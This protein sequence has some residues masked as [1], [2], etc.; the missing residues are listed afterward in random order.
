MSDR[1]GQV[2]GNYKLLR[3]LGQGGF[4]DV[5]LAEQVHLGT[6]AAIKIL[7]TQLT[8]DN[9]EKFRT[10]ARTL[11]HLKHPNIVQVL[12]FG[13]IGATPYL[14]MQH[15]LNGTLRQRHP[16]G[17]A[18]ALNVVLSY[19]KPMA[20]ALQYAHNQRFIHRDVKP[21][22]MLIGEQNQLLLSDFGIAVV[23]SSSHQGSALVDPAGTAA[24]MAPELIQ[25]RAVV[26]SDQYAL[27]I[28][29]Y[30]WLTGGVPFNGSYMEIVSQQVSAS[31][32]SLRKKMPSLPVDV[33]E[34]IMIAL[35]KDP[36]KRFGRIEAFAQALAQAAQSKQ[37]AVNVSSQ[38][39]TPEVSTMEFALVGPLGRTILG[40]TKVTI[41]RAPD[42]TLVLPDANV[43]Q[44]HAELRPEGPFYSLID[45]SNGYGTF[46]NE[47]LMYG[48]MPRMLQPSD[49]I[50]IG[51]TKF[52]FTVDSGAQKAYSVSSDQLPPVLP[53]YV[54]NTGYGMGDYPGMPAPGQPSAYPN[55]NSQLP[56]YISPAAQQS[57]N[58]PNY[59]GSPTPVPPA[60]YTPNF[61]APQNP[62]PPVNY[63]PNYSGMP[64][65]PVPQAN[66]SANYPPNYTGA[67]TPV[68]P[69]KRRSPIMMI[70][71]AVMAVIL[72][73]AGIIGFS[74]YHN[75]QVALDNT[76]ATATAVQ[77]LSNNHAT[78]TLVTQ[79]HVSATATSIV[80]LTATATTSPYPPFTKLALN[81]AFATASADWRSSAICQ[82][83]TGG[84]TISVMQANILQECMNSSVQYGEIAYEVM[85]TVHTGD[86]GGLIFRYVDNNN[87]YFFEVCQNGTYNLKNYVGNNLSTLFPN[88]KASSA[89]KAGLD[90]SNLIA[91]T[92]QG[93]T[94]NMYVN[95]TLI[96]T[97]T[98]A[99]LMTNAMNQGSIGL[100]ADD[101][102][103]PTSVIYKN[104]LVW[105][106]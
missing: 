70:I 27:A 106:M 73:T 92:L 76:H 52:T 48:G 51:S 88:F 100:L 13:V 79:Q 43:S 91:I 78:A 86:C 9:R 1:V 2:L 68:T 6:Y 96:D 28:T 14:V 95:N 50:R 22:N 63:T 103:D 67:Q 25:G 36:Q 69:P 26:A 18:V 66:Y 49:V 21:E 62:V 17:T 105:T 82:F 53:N 44:Y 81:D 23:D 75:N 77:T 56:T 30:E 31:P 55:P 3:L 37:E 83:A 39:N 94:V 61:N 10:E 97:A 34:V 93:D 87:F 85:M 99:A 98:S 47:Q 5:Y 38:E 80:H 60:N 20:A 71:S 16:R 74:V 19:V 104:A 54:P 58:M 89:I 7:R 45:L 8:E 72:L 42:N 90:A 12:D 102:P 101:S 24:Y 64:P 41:G 32:V 15:A 57:G 33:E 29:V 40:A 4:S 46:V 35:N 11:A 65:M 59:G 84:Y